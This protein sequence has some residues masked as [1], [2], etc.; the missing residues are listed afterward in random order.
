MFSYRF[1]REARRV[2]GGGGSAPRYYGATAISDLDQLHLG[3]YAE[4]GYNE[5]IKLTSEVCKTSKFMFGSVQAF[6]AS[7]HGREQTASLVLASRG[8]L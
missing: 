5:R 3:D 7:P 6:R 2:G 8:S 4:H 1:P